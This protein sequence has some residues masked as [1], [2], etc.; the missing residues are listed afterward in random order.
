M[1]HRDR[2]T[3]NLE[4]GFVVFLI[5]MRVNRP[6]LI[7]K[8]WPVA[9]AMPRMLKELYRQPELGYSSFTSRF[10]DSLGTA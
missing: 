3:A 2:L 6:L 1:I 5:G 7:H 8:W 10:G 9:V 4:G